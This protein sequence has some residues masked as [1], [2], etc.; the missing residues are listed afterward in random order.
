[1]T[2][3]FLR[4]PSPVHV[5]YLRNMGVRSSLAISIVVDD[6][7]WGMIACHHHAPR[8]IDWL[9]RSACELIARNLSL[10][11]TLRNSNEMWA[12][13]QAAQKLLD[14]FTERLEVSGARVDGAAFDDPLFRDLMDSDGI[15]AR[16]DGVVSTHGVALSHDTMLPVIEKLKAT[17]ARGTAAC[18][19]LAA[20]DPSATAYASEASGAVY[21]DLGR[22]GN[23]YLLFVR[24]EYVRTIKWGGNPDKSVTADADGKLHPRTS[25]AAWQEV[26][27]GR[28]RPWS[29]LELETG[30]FIREGITHIR[31]L[32]R[33]RELEALQDG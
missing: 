25:F 18:D 31:D 17:A 20:I 30:R 21:I 22:R 19:R 7:L 13:R 28:S 9:T 23:N 24:R 29:P 8:P 27:R 33:L 3:T 12:M 5:E 14:D 4:S 10:Q 26:V 15:V 16:I 32:A 2:H 1:M 11:I 6:R